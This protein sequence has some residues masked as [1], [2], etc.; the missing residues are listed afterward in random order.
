M[1][2]QKGLYYSIVLDDHSEYEGKFIAEGYD[3]SPDGNGEL[4]Y[5]FEVGQPT[6]LMVFPWELKQ[7]E[8]I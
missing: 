5:F 2:L 1:N 8:M 4:V 7:I 3:E 6:R